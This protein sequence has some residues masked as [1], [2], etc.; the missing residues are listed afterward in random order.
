[1]VPPSPKLEFVNILGSVIDQQLP[2]WASKRNIAA[3]R[4]MFSSIRFAS[5]LHDIYISIKL[6]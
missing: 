5:L 4:R 6:A 3:D 2:L 1:M